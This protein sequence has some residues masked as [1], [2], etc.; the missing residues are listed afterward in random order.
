MTRSYDWG[1]AS[2]SKPAKK[3]AMLAVLVFLP[4]AVV[5]HGND[6]WQNNH[7]PYDAANDLECDI[8]AVFLILVTTAT[9]VTLSYFGVFFVVVT[10]TT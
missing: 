3:S 8:A 7:A 1:V 6:D 10:F 2:H 4:V 5:R 9:L